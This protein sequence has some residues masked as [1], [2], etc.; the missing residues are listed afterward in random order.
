MGAIGR[1]VIFLKLSADTELNELSVTDDTVVILDAFDE[2]GISHISEVAQRLGL[3][4]WKYQGIPI[5]V[6]CRANFVEFL[7]DYDFETLYLEDLTVQDVKDYVAKVG[8]HNPDEVVRMLRDSE[9]G[10]M[11]TTPFN[12]KFA[13]GKIKENEGHYSLP[14][15][16]TQL[17]EQYV[18]DLFETEKNKSLEDNR[19]SFAANL[20]LLKKLALVLMMA[21]LN[22][23][24]DEEVQQ[25]IG[26]DEQLTFLKRNGVILV[27]NHKWRFQNNTFKEFI[28]SLA[29]ADKSVDE[30]KKLVCYASTDKIKPGW[31]NVIGFWIRLK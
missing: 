25:V 20:R 1:N 5:V 19:S 24:S 2:C 28:A 11:C 12:L 15:S 4:A 14:V 6:S 18:E 26:K 21:D 8:F 31:Y 10:S 30:V 29:L 9:I 17:Y 13:V 27:G 23:L 16:I 7:K 3:F 22:S